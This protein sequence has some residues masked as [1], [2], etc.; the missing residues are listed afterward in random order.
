V[1]HASKCVLICSLCWPLLSSWPNA[2]TAG[3]LGPLCNLATRPVL[4]SR[5]PSVDVS[6]AVV[7]IRPLPCLL[8]NWACKIA[9]L[10][11]VR[12]PR[13]SYYRILASPSGSPSSL[14][15][16]TARSCSRSSVGRLQT[17]PAAE[18]LNRPSGGVPVGTEDDR[19]GYQQRPAGAAGAV[20]ALRWQLAVRPGPSRQPA[21]SQQQPASRKLPTPYCPFGR[22]K[23][24]FFQ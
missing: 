15:L 23:S 1:R 11:A 9:V 4:A 12:T 5:A 24:R 22:Y 10:F 18:G 20:A 2:G 7:T 16:A 21:G 19:L 3:P 6:G 8:A 17:A 14:S 13:S